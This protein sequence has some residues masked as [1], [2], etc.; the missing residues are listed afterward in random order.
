MAA[1][2]NIPTPVTLNA[3]GRVAGDLACIQCGYN[4]RTLHREAKC[5]ECGLEVARSMRGDRLRYSDPAWLAKV[6]VGG[7]A[8][9]TIRALLHEPAQLDLLQRFCRNHKITSTNP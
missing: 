9:R 3:E 7:E 5:P 2:N 8:D 1:E 4:L 6:A